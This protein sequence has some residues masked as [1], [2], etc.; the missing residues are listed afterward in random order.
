M[1]NNKLLEAN[2]IAERFALALGQIKAETGLNQQEI[3]KRIGV[4]PA[5]LSQIKSGS[6][7]KPSLQTLLLLR[8][9]FGI[10]PH[11]LETG[12]GEPR[13]PLP[14]PE[15]ANEY[16][17]V[18]WLL[19]NGELATD[20]A[21]LCFLASWV[22][23]S[24][25][26]NPGQLRLVEVSGKAL[27]PQLCDGDAVLCDL[28]RVYVQPGRYYLLQLGDALTIKQLQL[29]LAGAPHAV[30]EGALPPN[31][32]IVGQVRWRGGEL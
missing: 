22:Q 19:P 15:A 28:G 8:N 30:G 12:L 31:S 9:Q 5:S 29:S 21:P 16:L 20:K 27:E 6:S 3:A 26:A 17:E 13:L 10:N 25:K 4:H 24:L 1:S 7:K 18:P 14:P 2:S 23:G 11:W 32:R